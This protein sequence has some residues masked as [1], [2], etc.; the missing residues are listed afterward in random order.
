MSET[1]NIPPQEEELASIQ[2]ATNEWMNAG[3]FLVGR[4]FSINR[5]NGEELVKLDDALPFYVK[6]E[7]GVRTGD[8]IPFV[9]IIGNEGKKES[10][11]LST[12]FEWRGVTSAEQIKQEVKTSQARVIGE[13]AIKPEV[14]LVANSSPEKQ[15][16]SISRSEFLFTPLGETIDKDEDSVDDSYDNLFNNQIEL[17]S[18]VQ[19]A[20]VRTEKVMPV[21]EATQ[22]AANEKLASALQSDH[23]LKS[24]IENYVKENNIGDPTALSSAIREN[25]DL[26]IQVGEH[27]QDK[28][29]RNVDIMP[30][31]V[32]D[33]D[34][35]SIRQ[36]GYQ[37]FGNK[38]PSQDYVVLLALSML[39]GRFDPKWISDGSINVD[40]VTG[41]VNDGQHRWS[42]EKILSI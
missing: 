38:L 37:R 17:N 5:G 39:D 41:R 28:L 8:T 35:K 25:K 26:R 2:A 3:D 24:L 31:R 15:E 14:E 36:D 40:P 16:E 29:K 13:A 19:A 27:L 10:I 20:A 34:Q 23:T 18:D 21:T 1:L 4:E 12:F 33:N 11:P 42:A 32:R 9:E 6:D 30:D 22:A 7:T